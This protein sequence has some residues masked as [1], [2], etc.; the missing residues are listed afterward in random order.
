MIK[1]Y[2]F[3][4]KH[5][6]EAQKL[7]LQYYNQERTF[8]LALPAM[9][10]LPGLDYFA[11]NNLGIAAVDGDKLLGFICWYEYIDNLFGTSKGVFAD[12]HAHG[13]VMQNRSEI[14]DK[15]Y[16]AAAQKWVSEG[17][18]SHAISLYEHDNIANEIFFQNGF[19]RRCVDA[20]RD[21]TPIPVPVCEGASFRQAIKEDAAFITMMGNYTGMHQ[22][23]SPSFMPYSGDSTIDE[24]IKAIETG[25]YL[26]FIA[27]LD[28][29]PVA[30]LCIK[31]DGE[32]FV[33]K[34]ASVMNICGAYALPEVRG[35]GISAGLLS[36]LMGWLR[37]RGY[38]RCGVDYECFNPTA[39]KFWGKYFVAY[40][41]GAVRRI[42]ERIL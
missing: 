36:W 33:S 3:D 28:S 41:N 20:I 27:E 1:I 17:V 14:Y 7:A 15:L 23:K 40:T 10:T 38:T 4:E 42:D 8:V 11:K 26:F 31:K 34:D 24:T 37:A 32:T 21:T 29:C 9:N 25:E 18:F 30:H 12:L 16:Q 35:R 2:D 6:N 5:V 39:R 13:A 22:S 19:G